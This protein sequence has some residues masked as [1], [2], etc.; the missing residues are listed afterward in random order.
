M[1]RSL[2]Y[3]FKHNFITL[4]KCYRKG[5]LYPLGGQELR[6]AME[7]GV[8][9]D[10][11]AEEAAANKAFE[12]EAAERKEAKEERA[13]CTEAIHRNYTRR[14]SSCA[15]QQLDNP[16]PLDRTSGRLRG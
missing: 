11:E 10:D 2:M 14:P 1:G 9:R 7:A 5:H 4:G 6:E 13:R 3:Y 12:R 16:Q 8:I 15:L